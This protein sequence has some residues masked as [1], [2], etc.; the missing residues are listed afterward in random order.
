MRE[1]LEFLIKIGIVT[2]GQAKIIGQQVADMQRLEKIIQS[3]AQAIQRLG[4]A[5]VV[6]NSKVMASQKAI[7]DARQK[8]SK[9]EREIQNQK[10]LAIRDE[11]LAANQVIKLQQRLATENLKQQQAA[12]KAN[13]LIGKQTK[14]AVAAR[15][16]LESATLKQA[17]AEK[18]LNA[19]RATQ[20]ATS[21]RAIQLE[22]KLTQAHKRN[23]IALQKLGGDIGRAK[24][25]Y[26][27]VTKELNTN[28]VAL[29]KDRE[30]W[31][32]LNQQVGTASPIFKQLASTLKS[33]GIIV[34]KGARN[35]QELSDK[36]GKAGRSAALLNSRFKKAS[37][38]VKGFATAANSQMQTVLRTVRRIIT[39][40]VTL[41]AIFFFKNL[42]KQ[43][44]EFENTM[45]RVGAIAQ[46]TAKE[47]ANLVGSVRDIARET[48]FTASEVSETSRIL[49][50][51]GFNTK[52]ILGSLVPIL[53]LTTATMGDMKQT[54]ELVVSIM[55]T[56]NLAIDETSNIVNV[57]AE[58]T[59]SSRADIERLASAFRF[60]G[61][62]GA[63]FGQSI[64][65][66][67]S[68]LSRF[69]DLGL[70]AS[71]AGTTFRRA[72]I[73]L[74]QGTVKQMKVL[75]E[76]N[77]RME[78]IN[79]SLNDFGKIMQRLAQT[80]LG[81]GQAIKLFGARAG[82]SVFALIKRMREGVSSVVE[83]TEQLADAKTLKR[84]DEIYKKVLGSMR[85]EFLITRSELEDMGLSLFQVFRPALIEIVLGA[86][87]AFQSFNKQLKDSS[88]KEFSDLLLEIVPLL[89]TV[90]S[91]VIDVVAVIGGF[92]LAV[93][94]LV[95]M[96]PFLQTVI[97]TLIFIMGL[98]IAKMI[99]LNKTTLSAIS[100]FISFG[101]VIRKFGRGLL[102]LSKKFTFTR[103]KILLFG[104]AAVGARIAALGLQAALAAFG[105]PVAIIALSFALEKIVGWFNKSKDAS[106]ELTDAQK[107]LAEG[108]RFTSTEVNNF[109]RQ[110]KI[111]IEDAEHLNQLLRDRLII[112]QDG[113]AL[114]F[115][116]PSLL[117]QFGTKDDFQNIANFDDA[118]DAVI[119]GVNKMNIAIGQLG[120]EMDKFATGDAL[121]AQLRESTAE[122]DKFTAVMERLQANLK[123]IG[124]ELNNKEQLLVFDKL[125]QS[126]EI[127]DKLISKL[128]D[129]LKEVADN[130]KNA[131]IEMHDVY[132]QQGTFQK[133]VQDVGK[134]NKVTAEIAEIGKKLGL[135][136]APQV[137]AGVILSLKEASRLQKSFLDEST[138]GLEKKYRS[139][140]SSLSGVAKANEK[141]LSVFKETAAEGVEG[142]NKIIAK[143]NELEVIGKGALKNKEALRSIDER[144][145]D[146]IDTILDLRQAHS[147][148]DA[149]VLNQ[150]L[151][152]LLNLAEMI[153]LST[154][155]NKQTIQGVANMK[156]LAAETV[157]ARIRTERL[158]LL[159][160]LELKIRARIVRQVEL[161][162]KQLEQLQSETSA[163]L[164][165]LSN[166]FDELVNGADRFA[167]FQD[168]INF[169]KAA[170]N[171]ELITMELDNEISAK[172]KIEAIDKRILEEETRLSQ[173]FFGTS[174]ENLRKLNNLERE[175]VVT[176]EG[177]TAQK[178]LNAI[179]TL[180][181]EQQ[182]LAG[183]E[184]KKQVARLKEFAVFDKEILSIEKELLSIHKEIN[185]EKDL[186]PVLAS[187]KAEEIRS[188]SIS[189]QLSELRKIKETNS[190]TSEVVRLTNERIAVL[191]RQQAEGNRLSKEQLELRKKNLQFVQ[192][193]ARVEEFSAKGAGAAAALLSK[194]IGLEKK[195][196]DAQNNINHLIANEKHLLKTMT[197]DELDE[198]LIKAIEIKDTFEILAGDKILPKIG[199]FFDGIVDN[200]TQGIDA[201]DQLI[202]M[203]KNVGGLVSNFVKDIARQKFD[204]AIAESLFGIVP[205]EEQRMIDE[206]AKIAKGLQKELDQIWRDFFRN[207]EDAQLEHRAAL[208]GIDDRFDD[209]R[210]ERELEIFNERIDHMMRLAALEQ[211]LRFQ[212]LTSE[213]ERA[214]LLTEIDQNLAAVRI[215]G[216]EQR[217]LRLAELEEQIKALN[218][219]ENTLGLSRA[220]ID[221]SSLVRL[222]QLKMAT[223]EFYDDKR[224]QAI[225][226][227]EAER[228]AEIQAEFARHAAAVDRLTRERDDALAL[229]LAN[230]EASRNE[231]IAERDKDN[232]LK[233]MAAELTSA[234]IVEI[235]KRFAFAL[236]AGNKDK[237]SDTGAIIRE[238]QKA[239]AGAM[240]WTYVTVPPP[241][242]FALAPIN[243]AI[244][245]AQFI[246]LI[247]ATA[248]TPAFTGGRIKDL[249]ERQGL[250]MG[251]SV[252]GGRGGID[253][254]YTS[255]PESAYVINR[256]SSRIHS[257]ELQAMAA[258]RGTPGLKKMQSVA[259]TA[260]EFVVLPPASIQYKDRLDEINMDR[261]GSVEHHFSGGPVGRYQNGGTVVGGETSNQTNLNFNFDFS[262]INFLGGDEAGMSDLYENYIRGR[263][264]ED[265]DNKAINS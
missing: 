249:Q 203:F 28:K 242:S 23:G 234:I 81:A 120:G 221:A 106:D 86:R 176:K 147:D 30:E 142:V 181:T 161:E 19:A 44:A 82:A 172:K 125:T 152:E 129:D 59:A 105:L 97:K 39:T 215:G 140:L 207:L 188:K 100:K 36:L 130:G 49:A 56:F 46:S 178:S 52:E 240:A 73:Q 171:I 80:T 72:L 101:R 25:E 64:E 214:A 208:E 102:L 135:E 248:V 16:S 70:S 41:S 191:L 124:A 51:A 22:D 231:L 237:I 250:T 89:Q 216:I 185:S 94:K 66:T 190:A 31:V 57:L 6:A 88:G 60:A 74:S 5:Q 230:A 155:R 54:T 38:G 224:T 165:S 193:Q 252:K 199:L 163:W 145:R 76:L 164:A 83:F 220:E 198:M 27:K 169:R 79:P 91:A 108:I 229:A 148:I 127:Y 247:G 209:I 121:L 196:L 75:R 126:T 21:S 239:G 177:E 194:R 9:I 26:N 40:M 107:K 32:K 170:D 4:D 61:P 264:Q 232:T 173:L 261:S 210:R 128:G 84:V 179:E 7:S 92:V 99:F 3:T 222:D 238:Q 77:V 33:L 160:E 50:Q 244:A 151:T 259:L 98:L 112:I 156:K 119:D 134:L 110:T 29:V 213:E 115:K 55:R 256:Q 265:I 166:G 122:G 20:K 18:N 143:Q 34:P 192:A 67:V 204:E 53:K 202:L 68:S 182:K 174:Q 262:G 138:A 253:D 65:T 251:G 227:I 149:K 90:F 159:A 95:V 8:N 13:S 187:I 118:I 12:Q 186:A 141:A 228:T 201:A 197:Q 236:I 243:A 226:S 35:V 58:A 131:F 167:A 111:Q 225:S 48:I 24:K 206:L 168:R 254:V 263:V 223:S 1:E 117:L 158:V 157:L 136:G 154:A 113:Q 37:V 93:S 109:A 260:R 85:S 150:Q 123:T 211:E 116:R 42:I 180:R 2:K 10:K 184:T 175:L 195:R 246:P 114:A 78:E 235:A 14:A 245:E 139:I 69:I 241:A 212:N 200:I 47:L 189:D 218:E 71:I 133:A 87:D 45:I 15:N 205:E 17:L 233:K 183:E 96:L 43:G 217:S 257:A 104:R 103:L 132:T 63:A 153:R 219:L 258:Q 62:A 144:I 162:R 255:L 137:I 146:Q 11:V